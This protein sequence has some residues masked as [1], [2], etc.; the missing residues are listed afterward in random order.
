MSD[1]YV[2]VGGG[3]EGPLSEEDLRQRIRSGAVPPTA[4]VFRQ[5]MDGW[6]PVRSQGEFAGD[7][8]GAAAPPPP[9]RPPGGADEIDYEVFGEEMQ[10]V[11]I[12][13]D[14]NEACIAE[15]GAFMFMDPGIQMETIFGDGSAQDQQGGVMGKLLG[16]GKRILTGES[17]FM[18][19]FAN[20][21]GGRQKVAFASPYP[22]KI[23]PLD[24]RQ[25]GG[26]IL[27]QKDAFLAAAKGI[28]VGIAFQRKLGVGLFGGE[29]FI[30]QKLQGD[31][32]AF[33]HAG[34]TIV[35]R[36]LQAGESLRVD[37]GCL[38]AMEQQVGYDI[39]TVSGIKTALFG[40][41]GLFFAKL[42]GPGRVWLQSLPFSR[43][44]GRVLSAVPRGGKGRKGEGSALGDLGELLMGD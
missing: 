12:T 28:S 43:L 29:G 4:Y 44:A 40:G 39:Q 20:T 14:P 17:L 5:G 15:A 8:A 32:F 7:F 41:E 22:G 33:V 18:T 24:L 23:I 34:G 36:D 6:A 42:T 38:V 26:T 37:T 31:G 3:Q 19:V 1:W 21:G 13:L 11:E 16:A 25:H 10:F 2:S 27:C 35:S 30:L 9:P